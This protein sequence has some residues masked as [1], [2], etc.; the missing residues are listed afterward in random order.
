MT[1]RS[2][3]DWARLR[4]VPRRLWQLVFRE[5][6]DVVYVLDLQRYRSDS[7]PLPRSVAVRTLAVTD[8]P[9]LA[10]AFGEAKAAELV[11]RLATCYGMVATVDGRARGYSWMTSEPRAGEGEAPFYYDVAPRA[12]WFYFF[13]TFVS[14]DARG[15]G[16][17][18][19]LKR[20]LITEALRR[21]GLHAVAT[22]D[23]NNSAVIH[24]SE[25]LGF[26]RTGTMTYRRILGIEHRDLTG[27]PEGVKP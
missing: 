10:A 17:A 25:K 14:G 1:A 4:R 7:P 16:L 24:V 15:L 3:T 8:E 2:R 19:E 13:D 5:V 11:A 21:G 12:G 9:L 27:L 20:G 18:T 6:T 26:A 23:A 22:H